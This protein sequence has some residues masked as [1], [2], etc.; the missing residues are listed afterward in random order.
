MRFSRKLSIFKRD[1]ERCYI[2][3]TPLTLSTMTC[4]HVI[5]KCKGGGNTQDNLRCCCF[6]CNQ[7][8]GLVDGF[9]HDLNRKTILNDECVNRFV[10]IYSYFNQVIQKRELNVGV[11][12][13]S[14]SCS[15]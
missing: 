13:E 5:P 12:S 11:E 3:Y 1:K 14:L 8:K 2:C 10:R 7:K 6:N 15:N 9:C 4:D